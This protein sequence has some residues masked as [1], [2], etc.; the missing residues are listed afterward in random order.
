M[1]ILS[2]KV[3]EE[4]MIGDHIRIVVQAIVGSS[5]KVAIDAPKDIP[6]HRSEVYRL[7]EANRNGNAR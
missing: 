7:I 3:G 2:R 5:V 6:V 4:I 1:L